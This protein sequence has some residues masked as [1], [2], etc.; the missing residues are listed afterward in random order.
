M[1]TCLPAGP[2][3]V[4]RLDR[5]SSPP[6]DPGAWRAR[7][8]IRFRE[9]IVDYRMLF[10]HAG[11]SRQSSTAAFFHRWADNWSDRTLRSVTPDDLAEYFAD[12]MARGHA[13]SEVRRER[14]LFRCFYRWGKRC[15]W[16][17]VDPTDPCDA[18]GLPR[19]RAPAATLTAS[20]Q[21]RL[22]DACRSP[23]FLDGGAGALAPAAAPPFLHPLVLLVLR[24]GLPV[25]AILGLEWHHVD[26]ERERIVIPAHQAPGGRPIDAAIGHDVRRLLT[27]LGRRA[28]RSRP[29]PRRVLQAVGLHTVDGRPDSERALAAL[30]RAGRLAGV[31][32]RDFH[33]LRMTFLR[34]CASAGVPAEHAAL[35]SS[36]DDRRALLEIYG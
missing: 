24:T 21:R 32:A 36:W 8:D 12:L 28:M 35:L 17:E 20:E 29:P 13:R 22:L 3:S 16:V 26:L 10:E 9:A 34:N 33:W 5:S 15:G 2:S 25:E 7:R 14:R 23:R 30:R 11:G 18:V 19:S 6:A 31:P 1:K 4:N 27:A